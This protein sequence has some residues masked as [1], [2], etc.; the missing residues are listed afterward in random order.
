MPPMTAVLQEA[1]HAADTRRMRSVSEQGRTAASSGGPNVAA[2]MATDHAPA[3][4]AGD[5]SSQKQ[6]RVTSLS[7]VV[8]AKNEAAS[9]GGLVT[10]LRNRLADLRGVTFEIVVVDDGSSDGTGAVARECGAHVVRHAESLGN[11]AAIKRGI[12]EAA[13][14]WILLM[15]ADGQHPPHVV[16]SLIEA[17]EEH[18]MV[19]AS[20]GGRGGVWYRNLANRAYNGLASYVTS[21]RIPDLTSGFRILRADVAK[22]LVYLLPNT[23]SYPTTLTL[24]LLRCGYSVGFAPFEVRPRSG[25]SHIRLVQDG[26]RFVLI[27]LKIATFFAPLR[28]FLPVAAAMAALGLGWYAYTWLATGRFT[29][30]AALLITQATVLFAIGLVSEQVAALR[31]ERIEGGQRR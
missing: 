20:R 26:S 19:V 10:E 14:D 27:I 7:V 21:R 16:P 12:R 29:N 28:V 1:P 17:A 11:G 13:C 3:A 22:S 24:A 4:D 9:I 8:P 5:R 23:F 2:L 18:D 31:F 25:K 15:D 6:R 30:M